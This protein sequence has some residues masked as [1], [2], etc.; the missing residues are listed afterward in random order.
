PHNWAAVCCG[1][2]GAAALLLVDDHE[3]LAG[4]TDR[5][6]RALDGFLDGFA[7]DGG[8]REG[9]G[10]WTYGFGHFV[11]YTEALRAFTDGR[12]DLLRDARAARVAAFPAL[13]SLGRG[14]PRFSDVSDDA[15]L[16][17]GL[18]SRLHARLGVDVPDGAGLS[19]D[20]GRTLRFTV[21]ARNV[22]WSDPALLE[23][24]R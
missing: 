1:S 10:Y 5:V 14:W 12:I 13:V 11:I 17:L 3:R 6:L 23:R 4:I 22:L 9:V 20:A 7:A 18:V 21:A 15:Q 2:A 24:R 8:C 16:P 19:V